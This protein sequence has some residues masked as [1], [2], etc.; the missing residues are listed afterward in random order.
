MQLVFDIVIL[1]LDAA[2]ISE[3]NKNDL[4][5]LLNPTIQTTVGDTSFT[6]FT[7]FT[8]RSYLVT[9]CLVYFTDQ[10][11]FLTFFL[12]Y[13][14]LDSGGVRYYCTQLGQ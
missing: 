12:G 1:G 10:H 5:D 8:V 2:V 11:D 7:M 4:S 14:Q 3:W 13:H 6:A 9:Q